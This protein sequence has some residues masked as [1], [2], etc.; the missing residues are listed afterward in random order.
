MADENKDK[1][2]PEQTPVD[3]TQQTP[4]PAPSVEET[5]EDEAFQKMLDEHYNLLGESVKDAYDKQIKATEEAYD[6]QLGGYDSF[7]NKVGQEKAILGAKD[8]EATRKSNAYRYIAGVGDTISGVA[9]LVG[10][11]YGA[12][13]QKQEYT[14]PGIMQ[15]AEEK[16]KERKLEMDK[17]N[18]RLDELRAQKTALT[19][20]KELKLGELAAGKASALATAELQRL[21]GM[22][23]IEKAKIAAQAREDV[24][25]INANKPKGN[26]SGSTKNPT[27]EYPIE[28]GGGKRIV[29]P[30]H[31]WTDTVIEEAYNLI[32]D[33][34]RTKRQKVGGDGRPARDSYGNPIFEKPTK[35]EK[36]SDIVKEA[37]SN[38]ELQAYLKKLVGW[39][40]I[41]NAKWK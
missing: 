26:K 12:S 23:D 5:T 32:E 18:T 38:P 7:I 37:K 4:A 8:E 14:A 17:L 1:I 30:A 29:I 2:N 27:K 15:K 24:A 33:E 22:Q 31:K 13:N 36:I 25:T 40:R 6:T 41:D 10:T 34:N 9:N 39:G 21:Q 16:R 28:L 20:S 35:D 19:S 3:E 11:M